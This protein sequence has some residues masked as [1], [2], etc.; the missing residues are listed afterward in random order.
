MATRYQGAFGI[1]EGDSGIPL[2]GFIKNFTFDTRG[3][4]DPN[5][6]PPY[7]TTPTG[8]VW[9]RLDINEEYSS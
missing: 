9:N 6:I 2:S 7:I 3:K 8:A 5:F 4:R 1:Y